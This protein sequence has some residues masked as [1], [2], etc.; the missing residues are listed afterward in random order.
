MKKA[1][2]AA[3]AAFGLAAAASAQVNFDQGVSVN[4]FVGQA[5]SADVQVPLA[6]PGRTHTTRD[7]VRFTFGPEDSGALTQKVYLRSQEYVTE[8]YTTVGPNNQPVQHCSERPGMT[9]YEYGQIKMADRALLPWEKES[10]D[11]C[12]QGPWLDLYLN[13]AAYRYSAKRESKPGYTLFTLT[14]HERTPMKA[15]EDGLSYADFSY[16]DGKYTFKVTD[17]WAKEYAGEN[18]AIKVELYKDNAVFFDTFKGEKEFSFAAAEGYTMTFAE[19]ELTRPEPAD[20]V[21]GD[22]GAKKYFLKWGFK[23]LGVISKDN[24]VKKDKTPSVEVK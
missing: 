18:V 5:V 7:C 15:D 20:P 23:R 13:A 2:L 6:L 12:L 11:M 3:T 24:F 21:S 4:D 9:W 17:K 22:R 8:C 1:I 16:A 19:S 14:S 10:F